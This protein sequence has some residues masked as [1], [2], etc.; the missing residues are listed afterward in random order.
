MGR[1]GANRLS[2]WS[3]PLH[4]FNAENLQARSLCNIRRDS[5]EL[6]ACQIEVRQVAVANSSRN[7]PTWV[8]EKG[9][10]GDVAV[11]W[12]EA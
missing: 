2:L 5:G 1:G 7:A 9:G 3:F 10:G 11:R 12:C 8:G 6:V 4:L